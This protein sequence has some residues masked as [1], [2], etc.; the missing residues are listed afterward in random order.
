[1]KIELH[2]EV[3]EELYE[4]AGCYN[5]QRPHPF[6]KPVHPGGEPMRVVGV[7]RPGRR[8]FLPGLTLLTRRFPQM[9]PLL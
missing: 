8:G 5:D 3:E 2:A 9:I 6:E 1:M 7:A 4:A